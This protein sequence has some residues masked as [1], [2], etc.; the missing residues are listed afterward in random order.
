[1]KKISIILTLQ[2]SLLAASPSSDL[3][4][5]EKQIES[6]KPP[7][8]GVSKSN[9]NRLSEPFVFLKKNQPDKDEKESKKQTKPATVKQAT[10][11][12]KSV[13]RP[14]QISAL[15]VSAIINRSALIDGTW[16]K[17]GDSFKGYKIVDI[18]RTEVT[19]QSKNRKIVLSTHAKNLNLKY[20]R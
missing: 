9:V 16:Y 5:V 2:L 11:K 12:K 14:Q 19:L 10:T 17:L 1:M 20:N 15:R 13:A 3:S 6:I 4:W 7:R 8:E 18:S